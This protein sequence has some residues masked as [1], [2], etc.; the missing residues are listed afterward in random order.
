[1]YCTCFR[2]ILLAGSSCHLMLFVGAIPTVVGSLTELRSVVLSRSDVQTYVSTIFNLITRAHL[3][4][5]PLLR[6]FSG[7]PACKFTR[8]KLPLVLKS[9]SIG[10]GGYGGDKDEQGH[11]DTGAWA[12]GTSLPGQTPP[13][14]RHR[15]RHNKIQTQ[16]QAQTQAGRR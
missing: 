12:W 16:T 10:C 8:I 11:A 7:Q 15:H 2:I 1:V 3:M 13:G 5:S 14:S 9:S 4:S 6:A